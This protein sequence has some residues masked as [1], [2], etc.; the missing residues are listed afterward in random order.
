MTMAIVIILLA[1]F[2]VIVAISKV[3][4]RQRERR[5]QAYTGLTREKFAAHFAAQGVPASVCEAVYDTFKEKV[6]AKTF[7]PSPEMSIETVFEQLGEDTDDDAR[8]ILKLIGIPNPTD[9]SRE[10]WPGK[11]VI[12]IE[13]MVLWTDWVR[14]HQEPV[15][16][17]S[18][19]QFTS[20]EDAD[21]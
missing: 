8:H 20:R 19:G 16:A 1:I 2:V 12:T 15:R 6:S 11:D 10:S 21:Y 9:E 5:L 3:Y 17:G 13:D 18:K 7:M 4:L 14:R